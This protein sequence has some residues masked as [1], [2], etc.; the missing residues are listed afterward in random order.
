MLGGDFNSRLGYRFKDYILTDS[1]EFL[2]IDQSFQIDYDNFRNSQDKKDN[3]YGKHLSELCI[4]H[5]LKI[6][7]GRTAGDMIGKY[8]CFKYNGCSVVDYIM[9]DRNVHEKV[10]YFKV[11]SLTPLSDHCQIKTE[12]AIKPRA[13]TFTNKGNKSKIAQPQYEWDNTSVYK[14][15]SY[16]KGREFLEQVDEYKISYH[17][18]EILT[19]MLKILTAYSLMSVTDVSRLLRLKSIKNEIR[20]ILTLITCYTL[21][22]KSDWLAAL[23][24]LLK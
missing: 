8:T 10:I 16:V 2:P 7:N 24:F 11:M 6:L 19:M 3:S 5:N 23:L 4:T 15:N 22:L 12:L 13:F 14:V 9:V 1:N 18:L 17:Q 21:F 20:S